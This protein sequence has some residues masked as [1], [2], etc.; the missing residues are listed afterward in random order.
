M[1]FDFGGMGWLFWP[2]TAAFTGVFIIF[3]L[4]VLAFWIWMIV[5]A[6][7]RNFRNNVEKIV[8]IV[9]VVLGQWLGALV[10]FLVIKLTNPRGLAK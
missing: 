10:Y 2:F 8:W 6:A 3:G 1:M 9:V 7:T 5:D 4:L